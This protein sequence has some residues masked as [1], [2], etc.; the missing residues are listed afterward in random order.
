MVPLSDVEPLPRPESLHDLDRRRDAG[1]FR[2]A[3]GLLRRH[4]GYPAFRPAQR[5]VVHSVLAGRDVLAVLPTGAGKSLCFQVPALALGGLTVVVSPL[6]SLMDDQ[7]AAA[8]LRGIPAAALHSGLAPAERGAVRR[9]LARGTLRLLYLSPERLGRIAGVLRRLAGRPSLLAIDEAHCI[10]EWGDD[11]RPSYRG[12]RRA[13]Y[14][15]GQPQAIALTGSATPEVRASIA[16]ALGLGRRIG[17]ADR[18]FD[19]HLTSFDRPNLWF[20][21]I[22][23]AGERDRLRRLLAL[24]AGDD[25]VALVYA[26]T[27]RTTER[28]AH[29]LRR[30]GYLAEPYHAGLAGDRRAALLERFLAG[31][32]EVVVATCAFG[33]GI[34]KPDVR[35]VVHWVAP[36]TPE[37]YYQEAGR[38]G[39]DGRP[40]RC[41][42]LWR[43]DDS[44]VHRRQLD[45]TY[46]E[47]ALVER[48]WRGELPARRA[49]RAVR[50]SAERLA[51]ELRPGA[52]PVD[53]RPV[54]ERRARALR[55]LAV[56]RRYLERGGCRRRAL[57]AY[58]GERLGSCSGCD[59]CRPPE[60]APPLPRDAAARLRRLRAAVGS[61]KGPW[62]GA[63]LDPP[64]LVRLAL[65]PPGDGAA[66]ARVP[67]VGPALAERLGR[68]LLEALH[69]PAAPSGASVEPAPAPPPPGDPLLTRL[70]EWRARVARR[71]A[72][73]PYAVLTDTALEEL[74]RRRPTDAAA[75]AWVPGL[76]PRA[77]VKFGPTLL[78]CIRASDAA[79]SRPAPRR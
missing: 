41:V 10:S 20:G 57:L 77:A 31:E 42:V 69:A 19:L 70:V 9:A 76:G 74:A 38:A 49:P 59:R 64:T 79:Q 13:R 6:I 1:L 61:R 15:L 33:M 56:M 8:R 7:V 60:C 29:A 17:S 40:S 12:L 16:S 72:V 24:L 48:I 34:D 75:L 39:R 71:M 35:L 26:P 5:R 21:A 36:A 65:H 32:I 66:L 51:R 18:G 55:R 52:G 68:T 30:A 53:W 14:L 3:E 73:P 4:F 28:V 43:P 27:R 67:G 37:S 44:A 11:F 54:R 2:R 50:A 63:L 78:A 25:R 62:G 23:V 45:V 47:P 58:F 22:R 46:P